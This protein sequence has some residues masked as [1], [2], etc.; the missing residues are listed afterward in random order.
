LKIGDNGPFTNKDATVQNNEPA[1]SDTSCTALLTWCDEGGLQN[2]VW[3][4]FVGPASGVASFDTRGMDTQIAIYKSNS[5]DS[6]KKAD[7]IAANDDYH[8]VEKNYAAA[9]ESI[10]V[11]PGKTYWLQMDGSHGGD[12]GTF[13]I[14][15]NA[16]KLDIK[17]NKINEISLNIYPNPNNGL[18]DLKFSSP[19]TESFY[20]EVFD[21]TGKI[22]LAKNLKKGYGDFVVPID[23]KNS[24]KGLYYLNLRGEKSFTETKFIIQ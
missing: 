24:S 21:L 22:I 2:S 10:T 17:Q 11:T 3:F 16:S 23:L 8:G 15:F 14:T 13:Y 18:M 7:L 6:I 20:I 5:C 4:K 12:T 19:Y 9:I 1:P